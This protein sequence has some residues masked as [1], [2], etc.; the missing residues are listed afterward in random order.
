MHEQHDGRPALVVQLSASLDPLRVTLPSGSSGNSLVLVRIGAAS[1]SGGKTF[2][3]GHTRA[4][5]VGSHGDTTVPHA[6]SGDGGDGGLQ[7]EC[8]FH[9]LS[10]T[11]LVDV[12]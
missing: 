11:R 3:F 10:M 12:I 2:P 1:L 5:A 8:S 6:H 9:D 7:L 4:T